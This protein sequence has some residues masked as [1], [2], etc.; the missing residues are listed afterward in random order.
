VSSENNTIITQAGQP[1]DDVQGDDV[2]SGDSN[3]CCEPSGSANKVSCTG[4]THDDAL[5]IAWRYKNLHLPVWI[6]FLFNTFLYYSVIV[7]YKS[8]CL[9]LSSCISERFG[10]VLLQ[11]GV[12]RLKI[13]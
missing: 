7:L 12:H 11:I 2:S 5:R 3:V 8:I 13:F 10:I 6:L 9:R 4:D 1:D